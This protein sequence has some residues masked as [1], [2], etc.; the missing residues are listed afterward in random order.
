MRWGYFPVSKDA[1]EGEQTGQLLYQSVKRAPD[2]ASPSM[3]GVF[4]SAAP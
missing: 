4:M 3:C 2:A 1:R